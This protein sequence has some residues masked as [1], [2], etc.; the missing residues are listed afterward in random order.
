M[1]FVL[2]VE[3]YTKQDLK[4]LEIHN[5]RKPQY[6]LSNKDID[7]ARTHENYHIGDY[8]EN[9]L[10]KFEEIK[11]ERITGLVRKTSV[12]GVGILVSADN[13][14]FKSLSEDRE[15]EFFQSVYDKVVAKYGKEN[16]ISAVVH[17]DETTPHL[18][19][20]ICPVSAD[21]RLT[22]KELF[23]RNN[24]RALQD[25]AIELQKEGFSI[26]RGDSDRKVK[27]LSEEEFKLSQAFKQLEEEKQ[28]I[29]EE[30][31]Q[32]ETERNFLI[33]ERERLEKVQDIYSS[34][35]KTKNEVLENKAFWYEN[36]YKINSSQLE[37]M[38]KLAKNSERILDFSRFT[39][40]QYKEV[41]KENDDLIK[42]KDKYNELL[43]ENDSLK[44]QNER[45]NKINSKIKDLGMNEVLDCARTAIEYDSLR[46]DYEKKQF[47]KKILEKAPSERNSFENKLL[48]VRKKE[49]ELEKTKNPFAKK[50]ERDKKNSR[51]FGR[52]D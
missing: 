10:K 50:L 26:E 43:K 6:N 20:M 30:K 5:E 13:D 48:E 29:L 25:I 17:K 34:I 52:G 18:H 8:S 38:Y 47:F 45:L 2:H 16:V 32:I 31:K 27:H 22:A 33:S 21:G 35:E 51:G 23:G 42:Y 24:L 12:A 28:K 15:K 9:Y 1:A 40:K 19:L 14:F 3:K 36:V 7:V 49:I 44:K 37:Q 4:G 46:F 11:K 41:V 39:E